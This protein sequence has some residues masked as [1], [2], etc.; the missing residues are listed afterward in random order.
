MNYNKCQKGSM[1]SFVSK[2]IFGILS[3]EFV[4]LFCYML[5]PTN[6]GTMNAMG[7]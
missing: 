4:E 7:Q 6:C 1:H 2:C 5:K 3:R